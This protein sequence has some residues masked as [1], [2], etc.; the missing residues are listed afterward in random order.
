[1]KFIAKV[2]FLLLATTAVVYAQDASNTTIRVGDIIGPWTE[3]IVSAFSLFIAA[4]VTYVANLI[5][6]KTGIDIEAS[7]RE[8]LQSA[9]TNGAGLILNKLGGSIADK[10]IDV[11]SPLLK[12]GIEYVLNAAPEA[13]KRFDLSPAQL[14]EKLIAKLGL[15]S[16]PSLPATQSVQ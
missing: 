5:R 2:V 6:K 12:E 15:A 14:A 8:A 11:R 10:T 4:V 9:L 13:V 1:M 3:M 16:A 7:H